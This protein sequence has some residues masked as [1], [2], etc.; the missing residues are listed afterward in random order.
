MSLHPSAPVLRPQAHS[1]PYL[2]FYLDSWKPIVQQSLSKLSH[3]PRPHTFISM[4]FIFIQPM[5]FV[6][7]IVCSSVLKCH[8]K[9]EAKDWVHY[10]YQLLFTVGNIRIF[11]L[12]LCLVTFLLQ[13]NP[14]A[15]MCG[16]VFVGM[17]VWEGCWVFSNPEHFQ[18]YKRKQITSNFKIFA[19]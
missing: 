7:Q 8:L 4:V 18:L 6:W 13:V 10:C 15:C 14:V 17:C 1:P 19:T 12:I 16:G 11:N 9:F 3:L 5:S 2:A